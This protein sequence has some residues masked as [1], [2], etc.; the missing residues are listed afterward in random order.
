MKNDKLRFAIAGLGPRGSGMMNALLDLYDGVELVAIC[1]PLDF[2]LEQAREKIKEKGLPL[3]TEYLSHEEMFEKENLDAV[4]IHTS[5]QSHVPVALSAMRHGVYP[6]LDCGGAS[7][8]NECWELVRTSQQT[9]VPCM[10]LENC[11]YGKNELTV[12]RMVKM[13]LFGEIVHLQ[14][15]YHHDLRGE[16]SF[17]RENHHYRFDH[18]LN[19]CGELYPAHELGPLM[20]CVD[21]NRGNRLVSL[22]STASKAAGLHEYILKEKGPEYDASNFK[23]TQG[24]MITTVIKCAHGETIVLFHDTSLPRP[25]SRGNLVQ[26]TKGIYME[27]K[28]SVAFGHAWEDFSKYLED[29]AYLHPIWHNLDEKVLSYGHDG[30]DYIVIGAFIDSVRN[31]TAPPIDVYDAATLMAITPLSEASIACGSMPVAIPDFTDGRWL[32]REAP[33]VTRYALD[34]VYPERY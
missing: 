30:I 3:P 22:T 28:M 18:Y 5:W 17:G 25:Y 4:M 10:Y 2:R 19:R 34:D 11:C 27:D 1:D 24:D 26:G 7:S 14:G 20:K 12:L 9:G 29:K 33:P 13:G 23:F 32:K 15:G 21:V 31:K 16:I 6:G 8:V